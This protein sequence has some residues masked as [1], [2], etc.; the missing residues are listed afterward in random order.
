VTKIVHYKL[1]VPILARSSKNKHSQPY[2]EYKHLLTFR[3][4]AMLSYQWN[5]CTDGKSA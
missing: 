1:R 3:V 5:P 2:S 4:R